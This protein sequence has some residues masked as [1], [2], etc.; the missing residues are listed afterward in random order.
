MDVR[1]VG[2]NA[3]LDAYHSGQHNACHRAPITMRLRIRAA[4]WRDAVWRS[5]TDGTPENLHYVVP[6]HS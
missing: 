3:G 1:R 2:V 4:G 5:T 6:S